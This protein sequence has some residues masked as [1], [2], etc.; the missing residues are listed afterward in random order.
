[1]TSL[2]DHPIGVFDSGAGGLTV[3]RSILC[4]MPLE[5]VV[6]F[7]DTGYVPYGPR[8]AEQ[9][10]CFAV[11]ACRFLRDH[12][13]KLIVMGCNMSSAMALVQA[14]AAVDCPVLGT[15][16]AGAS[17]AVEATR[18][19]R[20]GVAATEG[21]VRSGAYARAIRAL[22]P[23]AEV[24]EQPCPL[25]VPAV[26]AG[27]Q[28]GLLDEAVQESVGPLAVHRPD[29]VILGCTHYPLVRDEIQACLGRD[30]RLV[31]PADSLAERAAAELAGRALE[32]T[33]K[34]PTRLVCHASGPPDSLQLW[35]RRVLGLDLPEVGR[36]DI[37]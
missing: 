26:E 1:M 5:R 31:D 2:P 34:P 30:V 32:A 10:R 12:G 33:E 7:G 17:A 35:A 22:L 27:V 20:I 21:T 4:R 36:I 18:T 23:S 14:R 24:Y 37:H 16:D 6:Y 8:P 29:T 13:A 25:L 9:I 15:I 19:G 28:D 11:D 3:V